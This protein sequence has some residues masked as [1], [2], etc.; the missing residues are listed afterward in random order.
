[1]ERTVRWGGVSTGGKKPRGDVPPWAHSLD[2][3]SLP[4]MHPDSVINVPWFTRSAIPFLQFFIP[5]LQILAVPVWW[6]DRPGGSPTAEPFRRPAEPKKK[7]GPAMRRDPRI[8][9]GGAN[10]TV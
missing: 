8:F 6:P 1:M 10:V 9:P 4:R 5:N 2:A 3:P 7:G